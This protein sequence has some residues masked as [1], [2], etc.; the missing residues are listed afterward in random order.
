MRHEFKGSHKKKNPPKQN[1]KITNKQTH[2]SFLPFCAQLLIPSL[3]VPP[4][5]NCACPASHMATPWV[6]M[7]IWCSS[8]LTGLDLAGMG[9]T[10]FRAARMVMC[11][12]FGTNTELMFYLL[13][14]SACTAPLLS[15]SHSGLP[16]SRGGVGVKLRRDTRKAGVQRDIP[17][18]MASHSPI[19]AGRWR[20][21]RGYP[22]L[23]CLPSQVHT[24]HDEA[25]LSWEHLPADG[26][27]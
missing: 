13:L 21:K 22:W 18:H 2:A 5:H 9:L 3:S 17:C 26:K 4:F 6:R 19:K 20:R 8:G 16:G 23:W 27:E 12:G 10:F 14:S 24:G 1:K 25:P 15:F 11:C 7:G